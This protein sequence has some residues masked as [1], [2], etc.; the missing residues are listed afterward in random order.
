MSGEKAISTEVVDLLNYTY[1]RTVDIQRVI[2]IVTKHPANEGCEK[3]VL[4]IERHIKAIN[5]LF[6]LIRE[7]LE[8]GE[9]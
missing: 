3:E 7:E 9:G 8:K 1:R 5:G 4:G 2:K 6:D